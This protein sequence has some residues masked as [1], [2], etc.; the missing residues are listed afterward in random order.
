MSQ[1]T[2]LDAITAEFH[3]GITATLRSWSALR[4]SVESEWGGPQSKTKAEE[5]RQSLYDCFD[6]SMSP[7]KEPKPK[8]SID[9]VEG[10]TFLLLVKFLPDDNFLY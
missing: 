10:N 6:F 3:A 7:G 8:M 1:S 5:L 2:Q 4:T 9:E